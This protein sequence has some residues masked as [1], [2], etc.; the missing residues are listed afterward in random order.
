MESHKPCKS[1]SIS[2]FPSKKEERSKKSK[3]EED[4]RTLYKMYYSRAGR[5]LWRTSDVV[6]RS[7]VGLAKP[8]PFLILVFSRAGAQYSAESYK[9]V[10]YLTLNLHLQVRGCL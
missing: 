4:E 3:G 1:S 2:N 6:P 5:D 8:D 9:G 7:E 10:T